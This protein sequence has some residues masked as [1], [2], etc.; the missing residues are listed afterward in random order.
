MIDVK[1]SKSALLHKIQKVPEKASPRRSAILRL[2][3]CIAQ[4]FPD[5]ICLYR[6]VVLHS[7][8][9]DPTSPGSPLSTLHCV[10]G[11]LALCLCLY[12][13]KTLDGEE[14]NGV[15]MLCALR[16]ALTVTH[17]APPPR[18]Q[19]FTGLLG[20]IKA[21]AQLLERERGKPSPQARSLQPLWQDLFHVR[22]RAH[23]QLFMSS[24]LL[25]TEDSQKIPFKIFLSC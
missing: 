17:S 20:F 3:G 25:Q 22:D 8:D 7:L 24:P 2:V 12:F 4:H 1:G 16:C 9:H 23:L 21:V 5:L 13:T 10:G 11:R 14:Q 15:M 18:L 19:N 6:C